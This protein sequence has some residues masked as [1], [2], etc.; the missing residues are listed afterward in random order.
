MDVEREKEI[1]SAAN[2]HQTNYERQAQR[3]FLYRIVAGAAIAAVAAGLVGDRVVRKARSPVA[4]ATA[5]AQAPPPTFTPPSTEASTTTTSMAAN[6][7][8]STPSTVVTKN[9]QPPASPESTSGHEI[10]SGQFL[11]AIKYHR[12]H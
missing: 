4:R 12:T 11:G 1:K 7:A 10:A 8:P 6:L 9:T 5:T 2:L 3:P